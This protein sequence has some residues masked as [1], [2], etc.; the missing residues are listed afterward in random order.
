MRLAVI[1]GVCA[2]LGCADVEQADVGS[3]Q[4]AVFCVRNPPPSGNQS[5]G[6]SWHWGGGA[7]YPDL[8]Y[9]NGNDCT[10]AIYERPVIGGR[11]EN[12]AE[13]RAALAT[14]AD[15]SYTARV[16][17][18]E[19]PTTIEIDP[20]ASGPLVIPAN[21]W[22]ASVRGRPTVNAFGALVPSRGALITSSTTNTSQPLIRIVGDNVRI[23]GLRIWGPEPE[24][25]PPEW[26]TTPKTCPYRQLCWDVCAQDDGDTNPRTCLDASG[27]PVNCIADGSCFD[28][29]GTKIHCDGMDD[30]CAPNFQGQCTNDVEKGICA[31][32]TRPT[33]GILADGIDEAV[34]EFVE[35]AN[36]LEIDN[37]DIAGWS[38]A[39]VSI[40]GAE[41][42]TVHH[43][44]IHHSQRQGRGYPVVVGGAD[45][46][47]NPN[48]YFP[49]SAHIHHNRFQNFRHAVAS[50][51][52]D[53]HSYTAD[54]NLALSKTVGRVFDVHVERDEAGEEDPYA[55]AGLTT[56]VRY[57]SILQDDYF[58]FDVRGTPVD[59]AYFYGNCT[60]RA[61]DG[62]PPVPS[63]CGGN[64]WPGIDDQTN[65]A[66][67]QRRPDIWPP[68]PY[69]PEQDRVW[70][71]QTETGATVAN[72]Y[73]QAPDDC[74]RL[75]W[76][77]SSRGTR[78]YEYVNISYHGIDELRFG[79]FDGNGRTDVLLVDASGT[80][81]VSYDGVG[82]WHD[83]FTDVDGTRAG[84]LL[85][86]DFN[87]DGK[88]D[89]FAA[90]LRGI[91]PPQ[92]WSWEYVE[93]E[94]EPPT[95]QDT[96]Q[97]GWNVLQTDAGASGA[98]PL[99]VGRFDGNAVDDIFNANGTEW[100][101][102]SGGL[103]TWIPLRSSTILMEELAIGYFN[104]D[105]ISDVF[106]ADGFAW[107]YFP[108]GSGTAVVLDSDN[109][110][111]VFELKFGDLGGNSRTDVLYADGLRWRY[112]SAGTGDWIDLAIAAER[113]DEIALGYFD[114]DPPPDVFFPG[115]Q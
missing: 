89:I 103:G 63:N 35:T 37:C 59:G 54:Y 75:R 86:G 64:P 94:I 6:Q 42:A 93:G 113:Y 97:G 40:D 28:A 41:N 60:V 104:T 61:S 23:T 52:G 19:G 69:D 79:D 101:Y 95:A 15:P 62:N 2:A 26:E 84:N 47:A 7:D 70:I 57:N 13:L 83:V 67:C 82:L 87:G 66:V 76:C 24:G 98:G 68:D 14:L 90:K 16:I 56:I 44:Y 112:M 78:P 49:A 22:L 102:R 108:G 39:G 53:V 74:A 31:Y 18:L 99:A 10:G 46:A 29:G 33:M 8:I 105:A 111:R 96:W 77:I 114:D 71:G 9:P 100:R 91:G 43:N 4:Q 85:F 45:T 58:S 55:D 20:E 50:T 25:C 30:D 88:T 110:R 32:C 109:Q 5:Q 3:L 21:T 12:E 92:R 48:V 51:G 65:A 1:V 115:C 34:D 17:F 107:R 11:P 72:S 27:A 106:W 81:R 80:W 36:N 73:D 38:A